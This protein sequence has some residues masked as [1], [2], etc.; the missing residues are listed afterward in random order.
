LEKFLK[1]SV[2]RGKIIKVGYFKEEGLEAFL[3]K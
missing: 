3:D 2:M 1:R